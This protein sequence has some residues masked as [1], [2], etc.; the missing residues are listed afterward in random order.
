MLIPEFLLKVW[1]HGSID[2]LVWLLPFFF[3]PVLPGVRLDF[4]QLAVHAGD[5][6]LDSSGETCHRSLHAPHQMDLD[7]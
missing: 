4:L 5:A 7:I 2:G 6:V 1:Q 3:N